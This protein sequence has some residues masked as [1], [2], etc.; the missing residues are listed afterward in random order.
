MNRRDLLK[1]FGLGAATIVLPATVIDAVASIPKA[2][3]MPAAE[4]WFLRSFQAWG[5]A[6]QSSPQTISIIDRGVTV[7]TASMNA[8]GGA[9]MYTPPPGQWPVLRNPIIQ[10]GPNVCAGLH[11]WREGE[12]RVLM[13]GVNA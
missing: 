2:A 13:V 10:T 8:M 4:P 7:M 1:A 5:N 6:M 3:P 12:S 9:I 11:L